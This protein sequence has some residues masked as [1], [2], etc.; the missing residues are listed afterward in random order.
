MRRGAPERL[1]AAT[2]ARR[3]R[4]RQRDSECGPQPPHAGSIERYVGACRPI[5]G[6][7]EGAPMT[8]GASPVTRELEVSKV[9]GTIGA[10]LSGVDLA[11]ELSDETVADI[12][13]ALLANRVV[14]FRDQALDYE[15]QVAF[16]SRLGHAHA[17]PPD[18]PVA[19]RQAA[20]GR[21][22]LRQGRAGRRLAH[23][24]DV[25][26]SARELHVFAR[27]RD[28]RGRRRH[29][30]GQHRERV[31]RRS[32]RS[33]A[34]WPTVCASSTRTRPATCASTADARIPAWL[35]S[36]KQ[37]VSTIY[38]AE[39][40]AV[41]RASRDRR[42]RV[43]ARRFRAPPRR[44]SRTTCRARSSARCRST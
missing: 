27:R 40:P 43:A 12:R 19:A 6:R 24:R 2:I 22:R 4:D 9:T 36:G 23:R 44:L 17:R 16:A 14:F 42:A 18:D 7:N 37:F 39:H 35:E 3:R 13:A 1:R 5:R 15:S 32:R 33:C 8:A 38:R 30:V 31:R 29:G 26:R 10:E 21:G 20:D 28:P 41:V 34:R 11:E 25:P